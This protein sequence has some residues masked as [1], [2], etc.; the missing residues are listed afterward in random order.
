MITTNLHPLEMQEDNNRLELTRKRQGKM[1]KKRRPS[2]ESGIPERPPASLPNHLRALAQVC[3]ALRVGISM[4][5]NRDLLGFFLF[6]E[7]E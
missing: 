3:K 4:N 6:V 7:S 1:K 5:F 2:L